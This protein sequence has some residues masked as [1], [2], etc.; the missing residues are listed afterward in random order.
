MIET[1]FAE[2]KR[3]GLVKSSNQFSSDW[4]GM[5]KSYL[6]CLR[7]KQREPSAKA[8]ATCATR[9]QSVARTL[10]D[11]NKP[12]AVCAGTRLAA[13]ADK[14]VEEILTFRVRQ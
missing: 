9:L 7:A 4:L 2:L 13:L 10:R 14:C 8:I 3:D 6:R 11:T 5:E 1:V 12:S